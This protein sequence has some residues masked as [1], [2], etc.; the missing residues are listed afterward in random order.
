[1][2]DRK[3]ITYP[4]VKPNFYTI[5][6]I[7]DVFNIKTGRMIKGY[8]D[9]KGY[10][11]IALQSIKPDGKRIDVGIHRL[12]CWEFNGPY[13]DKSNQVNHIDGCKYNNIPENLEWCTNGENVK[14]AI[15]TGLLKVNRRYDYDEEIISKACDLIILG[16]TNIEITEFIYNGIDIHSEE[17]GNF[18]I[19]LACIRAGKSYQNIMDNRRSLFNKND[20]NFINIDEIRKSVK[21]T[22]T[23]KTDRETRDL[24]KRY[25]KEGYSKLDILEKLTGYR[26]SS[27][28]VYTKRIYKMIS[29]IFK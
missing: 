2:D 28:T 24:I 4:G 12:V 1:M 16:L 22:R 25:I 17:Q 21:E 15:H 5:N 26:S 10:N 3:I 23:N 9:G 19:T 8:T 20:Y 29:D 27:V 11:R 13:N 14:H 6:S 7:G 18:I